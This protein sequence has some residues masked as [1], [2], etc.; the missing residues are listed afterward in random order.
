MAGIKRSAAQDVNIGL[1]LAITGPCTRV[2]RSRAL[3]L[4][5]SLALLFPHIAAALPACTVNVSNAID[6]GVYDPFLASP[7][8]G[9]GM[10]YYECPPGLSIEIQL[11]P[12]GSGTF[13]NRAMSSGSDR[14]EYNLYLDAQ[15]TEI[16]GDGTGN[17]GIGPRETAKSGTQITAY[18]FGRIFA[19]QDVALGTYQDT[20]VV[21]VNL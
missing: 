11:G 14:L 13:T 1:R 17:T 21:T 8:D 5:A 9:T 4:A 3:L 2:Q 20:V 7:L 16:W 15:R 6:F 10:L 12:G 18:V 19:Q